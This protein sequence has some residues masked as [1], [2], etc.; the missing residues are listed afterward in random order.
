MVN[1]D[2]L[3]VSKM[4]PHND[5]NDFSYIYNIIFLWTIFLYVCMCVCVSAYKLQIKNKL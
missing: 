2:M 5:I 4:H 3:D 1:T